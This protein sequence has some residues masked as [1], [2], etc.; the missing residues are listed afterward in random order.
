M[1]VKKLR[2]GPR[3]TNRFIFCVVLFDFVATVSVLCGCA[4]VC[5]ADV[6][7][8]VDGWIGALM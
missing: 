5:S 2:G 3:F 1:T 6:L 7:L 8:C 4:S